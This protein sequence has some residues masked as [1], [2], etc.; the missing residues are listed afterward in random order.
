M[1][2]EAKERGLANL[3]PFKPGQSGNPG[4]RSKAQIDVRDA[5]RAYTQEAIDTLVRVMRS[6]RPGEAVLAANA[7]LDRGWGKP[8]LSA[9]VNLKRDINDYTNAELAAIIAA[10]K[11]DELVH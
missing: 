1:E 9:D 3:K 8:Q 6:G 11:E 10:A 5:A 4:G 2:D 7:L